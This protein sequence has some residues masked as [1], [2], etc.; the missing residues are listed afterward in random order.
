MNND[1]CKLCYTFC[2][3]DILEI[4]KQVQP[5]VAFPFSFREVTL[6]EIINEIKSLDESKVAQSNDIPGAHQAGESRG[7]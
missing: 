2:Y 7:P 3:T 5:D 1:C 4:K 6:N